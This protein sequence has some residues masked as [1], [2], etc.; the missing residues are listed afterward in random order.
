[1]LCFPFQTNRMKILVCNVVGSLAF[2]HLL[3]IM[4]RG[5]PTL[6]WKSFIMRKDDGYSMQ[7][8]LR[9]VSFEWMNQWTFEF[10]RI[11]CIHVCLSMCATSTSKRDKTSKRGRE[12]T[13]RTLLEFFHQCWRC[14]RISSSSSKQ[15]SLTL[16]NFLLLWL[17]LLF[18]PSCFFL[19]HS[20]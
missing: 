13:R 16:I 2:I 9:F 4:L 12:R 20:V 14:T 17:P 1:M 11:P 18:L 10:S 15:Q 7:I 3:N 19:F 8:Q 6:R 5:Q